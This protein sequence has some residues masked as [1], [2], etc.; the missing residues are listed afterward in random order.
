VLGYAPGRQVFAEKDAQ[1]CASQGTLIVKYGGSAITQKSTLETLKPDALA[2]SAIH[3]ADAYQS[4]NWSRVIVVHGA[5]NNLKGAHSAKE[6]S[7]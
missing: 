1:K 4:G 7:S 6:L 2:S 3:I 5:G